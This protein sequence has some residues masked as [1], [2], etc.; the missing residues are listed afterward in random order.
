[1]GWFKGVNPVT[2]EELV[3]LGVRYGGGSKETTEAK[4]AWELEQEDGDSQPASST[5]DAVLSGKSLYLSLSFLTC[6][7]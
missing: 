2:P 5:D 1:M 4:G 6:K 7:N 3:W